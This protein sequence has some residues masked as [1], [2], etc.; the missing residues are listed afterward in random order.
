VKRAV[1]VVC[2]ALGVASP[3]PGRAQADEPA[4]VP[5][6]GAPGGS[7][8]DRA[9][10]EEEIRKELGNAPSGAAGAPAQGAQGAQGPAPGGSQVSGAAPAQQGGQGGT[11]GNPIA[12]LLLM[13]DVSA[14]ASF[15][16][17]YDGYDVEQLSPDRGDLFG[18]KGQPTFIFQEVELGLQAVVDPY[19]RA[20][21][22]VSFTESGVDVEEAYATTLALPA[23]LQIRAGKFFTPFGRMNQQHPHVWEFVDPPLARGRLLA[24]EVLSGP[25]LVAS[26]LAPLPWFAQLELTAQTTTPYDGLSPELTGTGRLLQYF[27]MGE[28]NSLGIGVSAARRRELSAGGFRDLG[29]ADAYYR[30]RRPSSRAYLAI[31]GEVYVRKFEGITEPGFTPGGTPTLDTKAGWW[32]QVFWRQGAFLGYGVRYEEAPASG[33][34][35]PA[36]ERRASGVLDW[37]PSEFSRIAL[38]ASYDA[39]PGGKGGFEGLLHFEFGIGAHG[40]HPF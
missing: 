19:F 20:D 23:S 18:K 39:L 29:G 34:S 26:W 12:R 33:A 35:F 27:A 13:P 5:Q 40:A 9:R 10:L 24:Q 22:F 36:T 7:D 8:A 16:G 30:Y 38:Q 25:G 3:S 14:I 15:T 6:P 17:V 1:L 32:T 21:I 37:Y 11:G 4:P 31:Q 28:S 2:L